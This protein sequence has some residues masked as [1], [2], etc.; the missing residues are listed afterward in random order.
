MSDFPKVVVSTNKFA[1]HVGGT[2]TV[3]T[4]WCRFWPARQLTVIAPGL[5]GCGDFDREALYRVLRCHYPDIPK[6]RMPWLWTRQALTLIWECLRRRPDLIHFGQIFENGFMGPLLK[7]W[8]G[9]P[10]MLHTYGEELSLARRVPHLNRLVSRVL[11]DSAGVTTISHFT[12]SLHTSFG[13]HKP[14]LLVHPGVDATFPEQASQEDLEKI[15]RLPPGPRLFTLG[16]LMERKGHG[17]VIRLLPQLLQP[18]PDLHYVIAGVGPHEAQ[19][20]NEVRTLG[21]EANV[22]FLGCVPERHLAGL[23][24]QS[25]LFV[26]PNWVTAEGDVEGFGIVFLEAA[27]CGIPVIGGRSGGVPDSVNDGVNGFLVDSEAELLQQLTRLLSDSELRQTM[28]Q[29]GRLWAARFGWDVA[30]QRV[31][32][33]SLECIRESQKAHGS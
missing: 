27:I 14:A 29:Q 17:R 22:H 15:Y 28:G 21:L 26:H 2:S 9:I 24:S 25:T 7:R 4:Q 20:K 3:W 16:R 32:Q 5:P 6:I 19:L 18:F 33:Y 1:P 13:Y 11:K 10:Y 8:L 30:A 12:E 23:M 31:W